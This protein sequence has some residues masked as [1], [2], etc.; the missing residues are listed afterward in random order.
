MGINAIVILSVLS[1]AF[2][3]EWQR[4][5]TVYCGVKNSTD[6][7]VSVSVQRKSVEI[8]VC[9]AGYECA[10]LSQFS[11]TT[12]NWANVRCNRALLGNS[13]ETHTPN[14]TI[15]NNSVPTGQRC[16]N[17]TQCISNNCSQNICQGLS[18]GANCS[19][20]DEC[21]PD[22]FCGV[23][24]IINQTNTTT[25]TNTSSSN[26]SSGNASNVTSSNGTN[27][28]VTGNN[29]NVTI[30]TNSTGTNITIIN[31]TNV[32]VNTN[33]TSL[34][35]NSS[36][37]GR[38]LQV[39]TPPNI[40]IVNSTNVTVTNSSTNSSSNT[41]STNTST[42]T[43]SN[44]S[45]TTTSNTSS[46]NTT[47][48]TSN[49]TNQST[50][51]VTYIQ[52]CMAA[53]RENESC[54]RDQQC[55][56]GLGCNLGNCTKYFSLPLGANV[57]KAEFCWSN[58]MRNGTCSGIEIYVNRTRSL[59]PFS[60]NISS[61]CSY[62]HY[63]SSD[64]FASERCQCDGIHNE[65][66]FCPIIGS[67]IGFWDIVYPKLQYSRSNCSG[68]AA[69]STNFT[70]LRDCGSISDDA[71][72]YYEAMEQEA[73]YWTLYQSGAIN[74]C[75]RELGLFDPTMGLNSFNSSGYIVAISLLFLLFF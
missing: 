65:T 66:G 59:Y 5:K 15:P 38:R 43:T 3:L 41:S 68:Q 53:S 51:N 9:A 17:D 46:S 49:T 16:E 55:M 26:S 50:Q 57:S 45:T 1:I 40:T 20:D 61:N 29:T 67:V 73:K 6:R 48:A 22:F 75:S 44:T 36:L 8:N 11:N 58:F 32:T 12:G 54:S 10:S 27:V 60:C 35:S 37:R 72:S 47:N 18:Q 28:T 62:H 7:C 30:N 19:V 70:V 31:S 64:V 13:S 33:N 39:T 2:S 23:E 56:A 24:A 42:T 25:T 74:G 34:P 14:L 63:N 69:H 21:E 52:K 4:C 71:F